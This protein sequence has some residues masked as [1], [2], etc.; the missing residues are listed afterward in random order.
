MNSSF[1]NLFPRDGEG[2]GKEP[3]IDCVLLHSPLETIADTLT[4]WAA[5]EEFY[6]HQVRNLGISNIDLQSLEL[7]YDSVKVKPAVVQNRFYPE[8]NF[9]RDIR[10]FCVKNDMIYQ[11][12]WILTANPALL[13][14]KEVRILSRILEISKEGALYCL[15]LSLPNVVVLDG[16]TDRD[17]MG[18]DVA[19]AYECW[20]WQDEEE[21]KAAWEDVVASFRKLIGDKPM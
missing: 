4:A 14:S 18:E 5:L 2:K 11:A 10:E 20:D 9:D 15:M 19:A 6:P 17:R 13:R 7:I 8:T 3:Y 1:R 16:T 21:N 12:F